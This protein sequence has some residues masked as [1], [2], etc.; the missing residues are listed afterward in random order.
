M[1]LQGECHPRFEA[2]RE[3][4]AR[5]FSE[6]DEIGSAIAVY[7]EG[8]KVV[9][10]WGGH[11]DGRHGARAWE[12]DT[13][14]LMYSIAK[15]MC[16]LSVH[17]LADEGKVDL[18]APVAA[19]WPEFAQA[20]KEAIKVR[21][22][23]SHWCGV[24]PTDAAAPGDVYDWDRMI[25]VIEQQVPAWPA[26][27]KGAYNTINIGF[28]AGEVV[29]RVSGMRVQDFVQARICKPLGAEYYLG[30]PEA[31]LDR[32]AD[33][34]PNPAAGV[35]AA[36]SD[37]TSRMARAQRCFPRGFGTDEQNAR[38]FRVSGVPAI[39]G[40][41]E[42]R[43]MARIYACLAE[44][45]ALDGVRLLSREAIERATRTQWSDLEEGLLARPM[46]MSMGFM[47]NPPDG[48]RLFG[49]GTESFGHLGSGGARALAVPS[50]RLAVCFVSNYQSEGRGVGVRTEAIVEAACACVG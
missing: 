15:S 1:E 18:E 16:A 44:G 26:E 50:Q 36:A 20:G 29:R 47:K 14:C 48:A 27:E 21:H 3:A 33:L 35:R 30:V 28:L 13:L 45:G 23:L 8:E 7:H 31:A 11:A 34:I 43:A 2:V 4:L 40:F 12:R 46:A 17:M 42:A 19:Y 10:L 22:I 24:W 25:E 49:P 39:A 38:R 37:P 9:D 41:G 32:C 6:R 5:N